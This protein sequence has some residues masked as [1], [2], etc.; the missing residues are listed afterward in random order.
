LLY[1]ETYDTFS[2]AGKR[3]SQVKRWV[4]AKKEALATGNIE[5]LRKS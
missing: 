3:E 4:R 1:T 5:V 2:E